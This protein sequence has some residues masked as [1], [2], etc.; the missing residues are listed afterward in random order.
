MLG[1]LTDKREP[2]Y[3]RRM[4]DPNQQPPQEDQSSSSNIGK[5]AATLGP[6]GLAALF[7]IGPR[8]KNVLRQAVKFFPEWTQQMHE[9]P[10]PGFITAP[11]TLGDQATVA[12]V[13]DKQFYPSMVQALKRH[14][15]SWE[16]LPGLHLKVGP[17]LY[18]KLMRGKTQGIGTLGHE[19][20]HLGGG[21]E[22]MSKAASSPDVL[23]HHPRSVYNAGISGSL[24]DPI[25]HIDDLMFALSQLEHFSDIPAMYSSYRQSDNQMRSLA[26]VLSEIIGRKRALEKFP[27]TTPGTFQQDWNKGPVSPNEFT[28][29]IKE[30]ALRRLSANKPR[31]GSE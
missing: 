10:A 8:G 29:Q 24:P 28:D 6:L 17:D 11:R 12:T 16:G 15:P 14:D 1:I 27:T 5:L 13:H 2:L 31:L 18:E 9:L 3:A 20:V 22:S 19:F 25:S 30:M 26:E 23:R 4:V 21:L 7:G